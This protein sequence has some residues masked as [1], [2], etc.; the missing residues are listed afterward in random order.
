[1]PSQRNRVKLMGGRFCPSNPLLPNHWHL[2]RINAHCS[3]TVSINDA[4][5]STQV[6]AKT[7]FC[8]V[9]RCCRRSAESDEVVSSWPAVNMHKETKSLAKDSVLPPVADSRVHWCQL[10]RSCRERREFRSFR[11]CP[12]RFGRIRRTESVWGN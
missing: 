9:Q 3:S 10:R 11:E 2:I 1:M 12:G 5:T 7:K 8:G 4:Q 6:Q